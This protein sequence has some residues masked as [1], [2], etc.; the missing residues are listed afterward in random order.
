VE[1]RMGKG[2]HAGTGDAE[3]RASEEQRAVRHDANRPG[4]PTSTYGKSQI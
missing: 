4:G 3:R 1:M 2:R